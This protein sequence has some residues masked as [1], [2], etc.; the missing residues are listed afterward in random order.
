MR[1][2]SLG[3]AHSTDFCAIA[4][5]C[6]FG[7]A[8][9]PLPIRAGSA[10]P[11]RRWA[12]APNRRKGLDRAGT[13]GI[14][15]GAGDGGRWMVSRLRPG[16][17]P[18]LLGL[19]HRVSDPQGPLQEEASRLRT[20]LWQ[21]REN[22][23]LVNPWEQAF[24]WALSGPVDK[25]VKSGRNSSAR[26]VGG[27]THLKVQ[28]EEAGKNRFYIN[29]LQQTI[30]RLASGRRREAA[31]RMVCI[32]GARPGAEPRRKVRSYLPRKPVA[33]VVCD[34]ARERYRPGRR[35]YQAA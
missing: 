16:A 29:C 2:Y 30:R 7:G 22:K 27:R 5:K 32:T 13:V 4:A 17:G 21:A 15:G 9:G 24:P 3:K 34:C 8:S 35:R 11:E 10:L 6:R 12:V 28:L 25:S 26:I 20:N 23:P 33:A 1:V 19:V 18:T 14:A 31:C